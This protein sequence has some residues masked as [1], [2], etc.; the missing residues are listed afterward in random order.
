MSL[1]DKIFGKEEEQEEFTEEDEEDLLEKICEEKNSKNKKISKKIL[2][3]GKELLYLNPE[4]A[5]SDT[6]DHSPEELKKRAQEIEDKNP[7]LA[8]RKYFQAFQKILYDNSTEGKKPTNFKDFIE[9]TLMN[10]AKI[11]EKLSKEFKGSEEELKSKKFE[12]KSKIILESIDNL[13]EFLTV[14][15]KFYSELAEK[16]RIEELEKSEI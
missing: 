13:E 4:E 7:L 2:T 12:E 3:I 5:L 8:K 15:E 16:K 11:S 1:R 10:L 9:E 6:E 14:A